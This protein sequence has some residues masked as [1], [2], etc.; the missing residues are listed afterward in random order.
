M[1]RPDQNLIQKACKKVESVLWS[2]K[3]FKIL[4]LISFMHGRRAQF[5]SAFIAIWFIRQIIYF[6][7]CICSNFHFNRRFFFFTFSFS[8]ISFARCNFAV[9][10]PILLCAHMGM[11]HCMYPMC[12]RAHKFLISRRIKNEIFSCC[13]FSHR[14][15]ASDECVDCNSVVVNAIYKILLL[16]TWW[17]SLSLSLPHH[18]CYIRRKKSWCKWNIKQS[19]GWWLTHIFISFLFFPISSCCSSLCALWSS[20]FFFIF[21]HSTEKQFLFS[22]FVRN[23]RLFSLLLLLLRFIFSL[24]V[25]LHSFS[26]LCRGTKSRSF[27]S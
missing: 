19:H 10:V 23:G 27:D 5:T 3:V 16:H 21:A 17:F 26:S 18:L 4:K 25:W 15:R 14:T 13:V 24:I 8:C 7:H 1:K 20:A 12:V 11:F 22:S 6:C 9:F 2:L